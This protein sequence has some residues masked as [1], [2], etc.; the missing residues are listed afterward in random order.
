MIIRR[1]TIRSILHCYFLPSIFLPN[2]NCLGNPF[3]STC[4]TNSLAFCLLQ[5]YV[6]ERITAFSG[7]KAFAQRLHLS[8]SVV[9]NAAVETLA[10]LSVEGNWSP[11]AAQCGLVFRH[12]CMCETKL[13]NCSLLIFHHAGTSHTNMGNWLRPLHFVP[14]TAYCRA[15]LV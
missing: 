7:E 14:T 4:P 12:D 15:F 13:F 3:T 11:A 2:K 10:E 9:Q 6:R 1:S 5:R 8:P